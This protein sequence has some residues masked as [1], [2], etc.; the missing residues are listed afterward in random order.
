ML[1]TLAHNDPQ[2]EAPE[3]PFDPGAG[4][5]GRAYA[6]AAAVRIDDYRAWPAALPSSLRR[7]IESGMAV[8]LMVSH[9]AGGSLG[10]FNRRT[11]EGTSDNQQLLTLFPAQGAP[12]LGAARVTQETVHE[13]PNVRHP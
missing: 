4:A 1:Q 13:A 11:R 5:A 6:E 3:P 2:E 9:R 7:G 10:V 12:A 8:P